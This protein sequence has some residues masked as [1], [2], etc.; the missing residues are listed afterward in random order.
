MFIK[1]IARMHRRGK[2]ALERLHL[3]HRATTENLVAVLRRVL[4]VL[5]ATPSDAEAGRQIRASLAVHGGVGPL[6][7]DCVAIAAYGGA[8]YLP[9]LWKFY[10]SHRSTLFRLLRVLQFEATS[11]DQSLVQALHVLL[12]NEH[13]RGETLEANID[14]SFANER[15]QRTVTVRRETS[16]V[17]NRRHLEVCVFSYLAAELKS[18]DVCIK[19]SDAYADYRDQL[20]PWE[21]SAPQVAAYCRE[22]GFADTASGFVEDLRTWLTETAEAVDAG[23]PENGQVVLNEAGEPVLKRGPPHVPPPSAQALEAAVLQRLPDAT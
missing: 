12:D 5:E 17:L 16:V 3:Q 9:L 4:E 21:A 15:W 1:R 2:E 14:L 8:N 11:Q 10:R 22:L 23:Y 20:L 7:D 13:R 18:G 6:L 19:G